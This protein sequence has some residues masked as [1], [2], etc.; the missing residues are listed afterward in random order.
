VENVKILVVDDENEFMDT[1]ATRLQTRSFKVETATSGAE[2]LSVL[3]SY[4]ADVVLLDVR[5]PGM[6]GIATLS[7]IRKQN[8]QVEVIIYTGY[9]DTKT[10]ISVMELG[11][12]DYLVKPVPIKELIYRL[13]DAYKKKSLK[14]QH[15]SN[16]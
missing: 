16:R 3:K 13:Q 12:F 8:P 5:M 1:L 4:L 2:A 11:A 7:A 10:A 14:E 6:D 9:A 15:I